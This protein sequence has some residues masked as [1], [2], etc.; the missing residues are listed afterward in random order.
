MDEAQEHNNNDNNNWSE[1]VEDLVAAGD[2][3]A[4]ISL[5]ES[6]ISD[7]NPSDSQLPSALT[8]LANLYS[9]KGFSL[10]A[11]QLHSRAFL[12]QQRRSSSG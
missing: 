12:L 5:L 3:D 6:V 8:D 9:S 10:K 11:D 2:A 4:A 1:S 7:L